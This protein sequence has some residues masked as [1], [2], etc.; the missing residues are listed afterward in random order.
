MSLL[1]IPGLDYKKLAEVE[2]PLQ[3]LKPVLTSANVHLLA[4][5]ATK[6]PT[7][8]SQVNLQV[9]L[10]RICS[11]WRPCS[12]EPTCGLN[13]KILHTF[14]PLLSSPLHRPPS[15]P[16]L[17]LHPTPH[18][19]LSPILSLW[20]RQVTITYR[21]LNAYSRSTDGRGDN[22]HIHRCVL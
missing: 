11:K 20:V 1:F 3:V 21:G 9:F 7:Q 18:T 10:H 19:P 5:L 16:P 6:I 17:P 8:V 13:K 14:A 22:L 15:P 12:S 2:S 4:K